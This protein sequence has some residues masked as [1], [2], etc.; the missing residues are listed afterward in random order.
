[1]QNIRIENILNS[2]PKSN[3]RNKKDYIV[4]VIIAWIN[5]EIIN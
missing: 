4:N 5:R 1:M 2:L 3:F